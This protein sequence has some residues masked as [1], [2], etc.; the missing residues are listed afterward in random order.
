[1]GKNGKRSSKGGRRQEPSRGS[2]RAVRLV[3]K[4]IGDTWK[5]VTKYDSAFWFMVPVDP[6]E[7][8]IPDY[9]DVISEP[10]DLGTIKKKADQLSYTTLDEFASD[11]ENELGLLSQK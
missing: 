5:A 9:F 11:M 6:V 2:S 7:L 4:A 1:M 10:M 8:E 3:Q